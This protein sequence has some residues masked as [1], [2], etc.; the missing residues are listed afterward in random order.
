MII[1]IANQKGGCGKT[2][3]ATNLAVCYATA[4]KKTLLIDTD[5]QASAMTFREVRPEGVPVFQAVQITKPT[6]HKDV[7]SL[8]KDIVI[9]DAGGRDNEV[10]RSA[11]FAADLIVMPIMP[12]PYDIWSSEDTFKL[13]REISTTKK[14]KAL[15]VLN[16]LP[17]Q[18]TQRMQAEALETLR[19]ICKEYDLKIMK[20]ALTYRVGYKESA[21]NGI[22][23]IESGGENYKKAGEEFLQFFKELNRE[24][25]K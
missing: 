20:S 17:P 22:G 7:K 25:Q 3:I 9:I 1:T 16:A 2:T 10:Y 21:S 5:V 18:K 6:I 23:V 8:G 12:A 4:G 24:A 11:M 13:Y 19:D 14:I 15:I